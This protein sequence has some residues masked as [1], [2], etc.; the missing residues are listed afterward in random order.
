[1]RWFVG[2]QRLSPRWRVVHR[3][4]QCEVR[5]CQAPIY[6]DSVTKAKQVKGAPMHVVLSYQCPSCKKGSTVV[7]ETDAWKE[8]QSEWAAVYHKKVAKRE[9][10]IEIEMRGIEG[11]DDLVNLWKATKEPPLIEEHMGK[12]PCDDCYKRMYGKRKDD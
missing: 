7:A 2:P 9:Y 8:L 1:M 6:A 11:P 3:I 10:D 5:A 12:C 4:T